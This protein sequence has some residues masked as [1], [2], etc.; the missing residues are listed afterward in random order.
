MKTPMNPPSLPYQKTG[1]NPAKPGGGCDACG[2]R[3]QVAN[4]TGWDTQSLSPGSWATDAVGEDHEKSWKIYAE[5]RRFFYFFMFWLWLINQHNV[6]PET[7]NICETWEKCT[8]G[9][10][11]K[12]QFITIFMGTWRVYRFFQLPESSVSPPQP[13]CLSTRMI[14]ILNELGIG[15]NFGSRTLS[16]FF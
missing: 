4:A 1:R 3:S 8:N 7:P 2:R 6:F 9:T 13:E 12:P 11:V 10:W 16:D 15:Q 5:H 14:D